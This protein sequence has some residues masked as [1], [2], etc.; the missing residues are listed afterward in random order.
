[1][2]KLISKKWR[3]SPKIDRAMASMTGLVEIQADG[4]NVDYDDFRDCHRIR[5]IRDIIDA[6]ILVVEVPLRGWV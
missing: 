3:Y 6:T 2:S 5:S 1:M 4:P